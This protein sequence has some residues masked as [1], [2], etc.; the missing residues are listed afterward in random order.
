MNPKD[1]RRL[2]ASV[3]VLTPHQ[4]QV[5]MDRLLP[6]AQTSASYNL[7]ENRVFEKPV[8]PH[9]G[10]EKVSRWGFANG[11]Q[12]YRCGACRATFNALTDTPLAGLRHKAKWIDYAKQLAE[13][14]SVRKSAAAVGVH[15]NT[16]FRWRHR[17]LKLPHGQ[18]ATRL[19]GIAEADETYFLESQKG[20][21]QGLARTPRKRG[22][23]ASKRGT[24]EEQTAVLICR[25]RSGNTANFILEKA[26]K[27]HIGAVLKP[28][29]AADAILCT[30]GARSLAAVAKEMGITHRPVNLASGQRVAAGVYHVQN[31]NAY[32]SRLKEWMRRFHGVATRYLGNYLGWRR[33]IER[34]NRDISSTNFLRAALGMDGL[35]HATV[36]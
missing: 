4:R 8:C 2:S 9:C 16:A 5:L 24:S 31:V 10:H 28:L 20:K 33:L 15:P 12:R 22:G 29:L 3:K 27:E 14:A 23:K 19:A 11:L 25:D 34:H 30:D 17:F 32:D 26:D 35:Q 6:D 13:G 7:V 36:T 1:F 18:Q 21:R